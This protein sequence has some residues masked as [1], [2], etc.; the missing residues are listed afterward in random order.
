M[1]FKYVELWLW[2]QDGNYDC[3]SSGTLTSPEV[4]QPR[5][6]HANLSTPNQPLSHYF[7]PGSLKRARPSQ[8]YPCET[9]GSCRGSAPNGCWSSA[10]RTGGGSLASDLGSGSRNSDVGGTSS[11]AS[12]NAAFSSSS[13]VSDTSGS[14]LRRAESSPGWLQRAGCRGCRR[15]SRRSS[16]KRSGHAN[17]NRC[18]D[19]SVH[20]ELK[21][22]VIDSSSLVVRMSDNCTSTLNSI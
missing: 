10:C 6:G 20:V 11:R 12:D 22:I 4:N 14:S 17:C 13:R 8:I 3:L 21:E 15:G 2:F 1:H 18:G 19:K 7:Q 9:S 5:A 16:G